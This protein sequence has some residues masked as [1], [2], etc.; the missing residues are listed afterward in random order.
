MFI[1]FI[2]TQKKVSLVKFNTV[3][4]ADKIEKTNFA[5][6]HTI[7]IVHFLITATRFRCVRTHSCFLINLSKREKMKIERAY[8]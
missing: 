4:L 7:D 5:L 2:N 3:F 6:S 1:W 8:E